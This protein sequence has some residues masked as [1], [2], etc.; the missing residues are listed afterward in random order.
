[1][2]LRIAL[3]LHL[4]CVF[5]KAASKK[6]RIYHIYWT[7]RSNFLKV[8]TPQTTQKQTNSVYL[9]LKLLDNQLVD[10]WFVDC[11]FPTTEIK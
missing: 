11:L 9:I 2:G 3:Y 6:G 4:L 1:M 10:R 5:S 7:I 8:R